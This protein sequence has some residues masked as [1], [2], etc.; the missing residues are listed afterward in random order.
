MRQ[1]KLTVTQIM[2]HLQVGKTLIYNQGNGKFCVCRQGNDFLLAFKDESSR[3][4]MIVDKENLEGILQ[5]ASADEYPE[6]SI[7][8]NGKHQKSFIDE[9]FD[10][11]QISTNPIAEGL[12]PVITRVSG[13][14]KFRFCFADNQNPEA[15]YVAEISKEDGSRE[16]CIIA[17]E[18][19]AAAKNK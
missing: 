15:G 14:Y 16:Y 1:Q 9:I 7:Y 5:K 4:F 2:Y 18:E 11:S 10:K 6:Y 19:I 8:S 3:I 12:S 13:E 17:E